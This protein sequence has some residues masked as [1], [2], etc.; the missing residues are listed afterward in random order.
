MADLIGGPQ[1]AP[2]LAEDPDGGGDRTDQQGLVLQHARILLDQ[3]GPGIAR[4]GEPCRIVIDAA[5]AAIALI[6]LH[7]AGS[8]RMRMVRP[9]DR[10]IAVPVDAS[11]SHRPPAAIALGAWWSP[12]RID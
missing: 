11:G 12:L 2:V 10:Q 3:I 4:G 7:L 5:I 1:S 9:M 6:P 8:L